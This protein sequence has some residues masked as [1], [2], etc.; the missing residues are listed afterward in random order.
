[1][2][3]E[4]SPSEK[5]ME[6]D[7]TNEAESESGP[8]NDSD[9]PSITSMEIRRHLGPISNPRFIL[10]NNGW[11]GRVGSNLK[12]F[13]LTIPMPGYSFLLP[14]R[15]DTIVSASSGHFAIYRLALDAGLRF[16]L[17]TFISRFLH[18]Y[19]IDYNQLTPNSWQ[20][21]MTFLAICDLKSVTPSLPAFTQMHYVS[22]VPKTVEGA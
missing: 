11:L 7:E 12:H 8:S 16:P 20:N 9:D 21:I 17:H 14:S 5:A 10:S 22:K 15:K 18:Y 2:T 13:S 6:V 1:M 19:N 4:A 3:F